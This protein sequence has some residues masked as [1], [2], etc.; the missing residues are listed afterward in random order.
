VQCVAKR[1]KLH[2]RPRDPRGLRPYTRPDDTLFLRQWRDFPLYGVFDP[3]EFYG[4]SENCACQGPGGRSVRQDWRH[5]L[6]SH[7]GHRRSDHHFE[8]SSRLYSSFSVLVV[9]ASTLSSARPFQLVTC[10]VWKGTVFGGARGR[11]DVSKIVDW[12]REGKDQ[13]RRPQAQD[14]A[15]R[16]QHGI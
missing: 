15:R 14:A 6:R 3:L 5:R 9:S 1:A 10:R 2:F 16:N 8:G 4:A 12:Y 13:Y 7:Y 11:S